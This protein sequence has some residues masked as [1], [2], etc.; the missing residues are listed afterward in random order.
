M[1]IFGL[2][3][4]EILKLFE[5]SEITFAVYGL[6]KMG[7]PL[8]AVIADK[9]G[10]VIGVDINK[11]VVESIN[12]GIC[13]VRGEPGLEE[14]VARHVKDGRM[15]ATNDLVKAAED[16]DV[17]IILVPTFLDSMNNPDLSIIKSVSRSISRGLKH[18]DFVITES[19][20]PPRT[21]SDIILPT[22]LE[23]GLSRGDFGLAHCPERTMSGRAIQDITGAYPKIVGGIDEKSTKT[24]AAIYLGIN[25]KGVIKV[26]DATTAEA[27]KV[28][29]GLYRDVNI[30]LANELAVIC[31]EL[32]I[33]AVETFNTANTQP[34]SHLHMPG[35][36][37]GGHCIPVYPYFITRT[38]KSP[39]RLL[40]LSRQINDGMAGY[41]VSLV[42]KGL[43]EA[44]AGIANSNVLILGV[45]YRGD[46][47][48]TRCS[49]AIPIID[50]LKRK[51]AKV[52][53]YDPMLGDRVEDFGAN[54]GSFED[55]SDIDAIVITSDFK[56]FKTI[57]W[58]RLNL[59]HK[60][61]VDGRQVVD[62][63]DIRRTGF[64]FYGI[65]VK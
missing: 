21:T 10:K 60:V 27:V 34:Y 55:V 13:H 28:F 6:G 29:E 17:K 30:A 63:E 48:E 52:F 59:R 12:R 43:K 8:A 35:C 42:E 61:L 4:E 32:G 36:G 41:T 46:V 37:V 38:V 56:E 50:I 45:A 22:L 23:S 19:T 57:D 39:T 24:A 26:S 14:M 58:G 1:K 5:R 64:I 65:G 2:K 53:A 11:K 25:S 44:G 47:E 15:T 16:S 7:L 20:L 49:P 9:G 3:E 51:G 18:G 54:P 40:S 31:H 33:D 62:P